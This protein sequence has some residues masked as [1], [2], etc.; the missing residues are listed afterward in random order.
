MTNKE[1][2]TIDERS[3]DI[4]TI[5]NLK[6]GET[7]PVITIKSPK[8]KKI[9]IIGMSDVNSI[10]DAHALRTRIADK[11][12]NA[13]DFLTKVVITHEKSNEIVRTIKVYYCDISTVQDVSLYEDINLTKR[14]TFYRHKTDIKWYRFKNTIILDEEDKLVISV[15]NPKQDIEKV[16][17]A[18]DVTI[19]N[20]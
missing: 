20:K 2:I 6:A 5:N 18:L 3:T 19:K 4:V 10:I 11:N 12:D 17:F 15:T 8:G 14:V 16:K 13:I 9:E 7:G 1:D